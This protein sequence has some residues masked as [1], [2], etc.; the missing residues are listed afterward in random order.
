MAHFRK[1]TR[2]AT[3]FEAL[4]SNTSGSDNTAT[5]VN[6]LFTNTSGL[7]NTATGVSVLILNITGNGNT[8]TGLD[9]LF[10]NT[11][12]GD[13]TATGESALQSNTTGNS[14]TAIG[15]FALASKTTGG[16]NIALGSQAGSAL[17]TGVNNIYIGNAGVAAEDNTIRIGSTQATTYVAGISGTV[18]AGVTVPVLVDANGKL[19][20]L[21]SSQRFKDEIKP[22]DTASEAILALRPVTFRYK[23]EI[24]PNGI[25]QFG[26]V[27]EE[28]EK[29]NPDLASSSE[30]LRVLV[31]ARNVL[32]T[33]ITPLLM[34]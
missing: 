17:T 33:P 27:A 5:G 26:L 22:M 29:V 4:F 19:G 9:A 20:A 31:A 30:L 21:A 8:A 28:V 23:H 34:I 15:L 24:D 14:N 32:F 12:G 6:A 18:L 25:P 10:S 16:N 7:N 3:G 11:I 13:N 2:T 1:A